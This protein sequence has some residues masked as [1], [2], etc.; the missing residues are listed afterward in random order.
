MAQNVTAPYETSAPQTTQGSTGK[1]S[2]FLFSVMLFLW[3]VNVRSYLRESPYN[4]YIYGQHLLSGS[5]GP[6]GQ[7][8]PATSS[9]SRVFTGNGVLGRE[10]YAQ[11]G[12][13]SCV[14][15][16]QRDPQLGSGLSVLSWQFLPFCS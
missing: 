5:L 10:G 6:E 9:Q 14:K 2:L 16:W 3:K 12:S 13:R 7:K 15:T 8:T 4:L 11:K 1:R